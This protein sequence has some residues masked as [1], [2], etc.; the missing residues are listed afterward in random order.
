MKKLIVFKNNIL[1]L[2][3]NYFIFVLMNCMVFNFGCNDFIFLILERVFNVFHLFH[4]RRT[5]FKD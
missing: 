5:F 3:I 4:I 2:L 1:I